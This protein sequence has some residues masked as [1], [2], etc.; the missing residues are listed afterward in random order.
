VCLPLLIF[1]CTIKPRSSLLAQAHPCTII[2][3][4]LGY[5]HS[6]RTEHFVKLGHVVFEICKQTDG[7]TDM[8]ITILGTHPWDESNDWTYKAASG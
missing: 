1:P 3:G 4:G 6:T 7:Q 5:G 2:I 8:L